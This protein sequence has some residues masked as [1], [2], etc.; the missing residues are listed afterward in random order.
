M[1]H[2]GFKGREIRTNEGERLMMIISEKL[3]ADES[4]FRDRARYRSSKNTKRN[5][6]ET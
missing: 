2:V 4:D 5:N 3:H 6:K 1:F